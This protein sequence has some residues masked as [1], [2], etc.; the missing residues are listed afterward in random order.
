MM[1]ITGFLVFL[2]I[3]K[4]ELGT[5]AIAQTAA[6][7]AFIGGSIFEVGSYLMVVEALDRGRESNFGTALGKLLHH[8]RRVSSTSNETTSL[9]KGKT[10]GG[11]SRGDRVIDTD[12]ERPSTASSSTQI[13]EDNQK[14]IAEVGSK[15][16]VWWG[17]PLWHD[18][19]YLAVSTVYFQY[20][21]R[22][23]KWQAFVQLIAA[24]IFW[25]STM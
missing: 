18:L 9:R 5:T 17:K 13:G 7:T 20:L 24:T 23:E 22:A 4:P 11:L 16:F 6:A 21:T 25:I 14:G 15:G 10:E 3:L 2:P 8:R 19:G 1:C 12:E